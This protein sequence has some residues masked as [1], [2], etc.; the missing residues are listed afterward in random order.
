MVCSKGISK[1]NNIGK[2]FC[3]LDDPIKVKL[4]GVEYHYVRQH[5]EQGLI[6]GIQ[7]DV[8]IHADLQ[9]GV[10]QFGH[11]GRVFLA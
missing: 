3:Q 4:D 11:K 5:I 6:Y 2:Y 1:V 10:H 9:E 7:P 8:L